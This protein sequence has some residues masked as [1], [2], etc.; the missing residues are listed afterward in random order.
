MLDYTVPPFQFLIGGFDASEYLDSISLSVPMHE[1]GQSLLWAGQF[2]VSNNLRARANG[3]TDDSFSEFTNPSVWRPFQAPVRLNI[4]GYQSPVLRIENYRYNRQTNSGEGIL[5]QIPAAVAGDRPGENIATVVSG[6]IGTAIDSLL[7]AAFRG[8]TVQPGRAV[9]GDSGVLDV[10]LSTRDPWGDAVRLAGLNW[11]W[12]G[13]GGSESIISF[14]GAGGG[15]VFNRSIEQV[16]LVPDLAA[17]YQAASRVIVTGARQVVDQASTQD[18]VPSVPRPKFKT[19]ME[20]RPYSTVFPTVQNTAPIVFE[21][22]TI[23]YQYWDDDSFSDLPSQTSLVGFLYDIQS[24]TQ[25]GINPYE[26]PP[27]LNIPL[28]TITMKRQPIGY[29]FPSVGVNTSLIVAELIVESNLRKLTIKPRGVLFPTETANATLAIEKRE[30]LTSA[31]IRPGAQLTPISTDANGQ[32][33]VY[34]ARP[35]LEPPQPIATR[36]LKTEVLRGEVRLAPIGWTPVLAKPLVVDFGFLPDAARADF[37]AQKIAIREQRRRDQVLVDMPIP[38]EWLA[39]D[40][41]LLGLAAIGGSV[42]LM[43]GCALSIADGQAKFG[44]TGGLVSRGITVDVNGTPTVVQQSQYQIETSLEGEITFEIELTSAMAAS[45][46]PS[47][48]FELDLAS[49]IRVDLDP[50]IAFE[51]AIS[52]ADGLVLAAEIASEA[53]IV[54]TD[55]LMLTP[56]IVNDAVTLIGA[57]LVLTPEIASEAVV[58]IG[59]GLMLTPEIVIEAV[60]SI[61]SGVVADGA[62][63]LES[64]V[65][66]GVL[67]TL[68]FAVSPS[69]EVEGSTALQTLTF[70]VSP[71]SGAEGTPAALQTLTFTVSPTSGAEGN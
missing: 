8:A 20:E 69:S 50:N 48:I 33:Q 47:I 12:L 59:T 35:K 29:L 37:L 31:A 54:V 13:V 45:I 4:K 57:G 71:G 9:A 11:N 21:E 61:D 42:Y 7:V 52:A 40:W 51:G 15:L 60:V 5:T 63:R 10:P 65:S 55:G 14:N 24:Q 34:E 44:F 43:D 53:A 64:I 32:A 22:K 66:T 17:I 23:V 3:L 30:T 38:T 62:V 58:S 67:Q 1:P 18:T 36:P 19:T 27:D 6:T 28:Q 46:E 56:A 68:T 41:P 16:E 2:K 26:R 25:T 70:T 39:N 49:G